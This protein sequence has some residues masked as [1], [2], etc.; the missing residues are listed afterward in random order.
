MLTPALVVDPGRLR[1]NILSMASVLAKAGLA[2]RPHFKTSKSLRVAQLQ[3]DAGAV[4]FTCATPAEVDALLTAGHRDLFWA[5]AP[6]GPKAALAAEF[7]RRGRVVVAVDSVDLVDL[8]E[9]AVPVR[10]EVDTGLGRTGVAPED[11]VTLA[12]HIAH[13]GFELD[14]VY[15][16]EGQLYT[17]TGDR[18]EAGQDAARTLVETAEAVRA[19]GIPVP[20]VSVGST[21]GWD[22]A[23]FVPGVTEAR[24][25]TYVFGDANQVRLGSQRLDDTALTLLATVVSTPRDGTAIVDAGVKALGSERHAETGFGL[26]LG[27]D[28]GFTRAFEEHGVLEGPGAP[29]LRVGDTVRILPNHACVTVNMWSSLRVGDETWPTVARY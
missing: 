10:I 1:A 24:P 27:H 12:R 29:L 28:V 22:S 18:E 3:A 16:H 6:V 17:V 20:V 19:D 26:V 7:N 8:L 11:A 15:T 14:G 9:P 21:P 13:R 5:H 4:G 23:P 2:L 25:G